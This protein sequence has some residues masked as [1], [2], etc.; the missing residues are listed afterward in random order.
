M[1]ENMNIKFICDYMIPNNNS[2]NRTCVLLRE[3]KAKYIMGTS[4]NPL[5]SA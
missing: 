1:R 5:K 4:K 2:E 3:N